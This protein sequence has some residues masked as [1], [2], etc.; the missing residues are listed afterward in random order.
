MGFIKSP[1][2]IKVKLNNK[3][4]TWLRCK[5]FRNRFL[6]AAWCGYRNAVLL[7]WGWGSTC[8]SSLVSCYSLLPSFPRAVSHTLFFF[9]PPLPC[10]HTH[11]RSFSLIFSFHCEL[12]LLWRRS[13]KRICQP[14]GSARGVRSRCAR[15][16]G[17]A[18]SSACIHTHIYTH[19][20]LRGA[21]YRGRGHRL[22]TT[23]S[24]SQPRW[25]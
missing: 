10:T 22:T 15:H 4:K 5:S 6:A 18:P 24:N 11:T 16:W 12:S 13:R 14:Y 1:I 17:S 2:R 9:F 25:L 20:G 3:V 8:R 7:R 19:T 23:L 21:C